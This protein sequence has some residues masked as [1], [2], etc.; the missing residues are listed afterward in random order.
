MRQL[1]RDTHFRIAIPLALAAVL[2]FGLV[3]AFDSPGAT[4]KPGPSRKV[5]LLAAAST[6]SVPPI[7]AQI[8]PGG[9][10][11]ASTTAG[12]EVTTDGG[13]TFALSDLPI[14]ATGFMDAGISG[15]TIVA[16]GVDFSTTNSGGQS[17]L[18][19]A[20]SDDGG[21]SWT[22]VKPPAPL[23][24]AQVSRAQIVRTGGALIG[25][26]ATL[27]SGSAFSEGDWYS[28][29]DGGRSWTDTPAPSGGTVTDVAGTLWLI[30]GPVNNQIYSS[31]DFGATWVK[32]TPPNGIEPGTAYTIPGS[33]SDGDVVLVATIPS[34]S[35]GAPNVTVFTSDNA[36]E[37]WS[38]LSPTLTLPGS[39]G[40]GVTTPASVAADT[41]WLGAP[42]GGEVIVLSST[43][44]VV[45]TTSNL[46]YPTVDSVI[47]TG[48]STAWA[49]GSSSQCPTGKQ[50]CTITTSLFATTNAGASWTQLDLSPV[51]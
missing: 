39:V 50:S 28:S 14:P 42:Y 7:E 19:T 30:G 43:G 2:T 21:S 32:V 35:T 27:Q 45:S 12:F 44:S 23:D 48:D 31:S 51:S 38:M 9:E 41:V 25:M 10:G 16:A 5:S 33:L 17:T 15:D 22:G 36:G 13:H 40:G 4:S 46:P 20:Y 11:W 6:T 3:I 49:V 18:E 8:Q 37:S 24:G 47:A 34:S 26:M 29:S 1:T